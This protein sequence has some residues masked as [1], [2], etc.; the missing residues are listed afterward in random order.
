MRFTVRTVLLL[1]AALAAACAY[2]RSRVQTEQ[3]GRTLSLG[4]EGKGARTVVE[5]VATAADDSGESVAVDWTLVRDG[6]RIHSEC[7]RGG[8]HVRARLNGPQP[9]SGDRVE[10]VA[11]YLD[12]EGRERARQSLATTVP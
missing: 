8:A 1:A 11:R 2:D 3:D 9:R 6:S 7:D 12:A 4:R 10:A 5:A